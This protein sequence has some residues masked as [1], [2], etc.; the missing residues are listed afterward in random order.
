MYSAIPSA[1]LL[2]QALKFYGINQVVISPGSRNAPLILSIAADPDFQAFSVIDERSA[3][4]FALGRAMASKSPVALI[5]TSGSALLNYY[6]AIAE[7]YYSQIPLVVISADRPSYKI[8][9]GDGQTI[10]QNDVFASLIGPSFKLEQDVAHN[11]KEIARF[12]PELLLIDQVSVERANL[13]CI[14]EAV[15]LMRQHRIPVHLNS[16][17]EE[18]LYDSVLEPPTVY[19]MPSVQSEEAV[20]PLSQE[21]KDVIAD[22]VGSSSKRVLVLVGVWDPLPSE[23]EQLQNIVKCFG[24]LLLTETT[25]NLKDIDAIDSIDSLL[26]PI[27]QHPLSAELIEKL[28]PEVVF[29]VGG[30]VVSKKIKALFRKRPGLAHVHL[31]QGRALNTFNSLKGSVDLGVL[32]DYIQTINISTDTSYRDYWLDYYTKLND[33]RNAFKAK[34]PFSDFSVFGELL[35]AIPE[36]VVVHFSNSSAIRYAQFFRSKAKRQLCNRGTSGIE[37]STSTAVGY[38]SFKGDKTL[39]ISG[40]LSFLYDS[41]ALWNNTLP[42]SFRI[43]V[44]NNRGGG[45]FRIL[46]RAQKTPRFEDFLETKHNRTAQPIALENQFE[47]LAAHSSDELAECLH[48]FFDESASPKLLEVFTPSDQNEKVLFDYFKSLL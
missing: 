25:S 13:N 46:P 44:V 11:A 34:A 33:K 18:P 24:A 45:I 6:P 5:C 47:Y 14:A 30:L 43:V 7:A 28:M 15:R 37:G 27:E 31:G 23:I 1:F 10:R 12:A 32:D 4:F 29:T 26:A 17:F 41:N 2:T 3:A 9:I 38:A 21:T 36:D 8:D 16:P 48:S 35:A 19:E 39:L 20:R 42:S 40:D 22:V